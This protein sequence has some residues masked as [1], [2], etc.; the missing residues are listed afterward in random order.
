MMSLSEDSLIYKEIEKVVNDDL[1]NALEVDYILI[2]R[3]RDR[4]DGVL[5]IGEVVIAAMNTLTT[6]QLVLLGRQSIH[7]R[8]EALT[9]LAGV[10]PLDI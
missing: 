4:S 5:S 9:E 3:I 8:A 2:A 6:E 7:D 1:A 10:D